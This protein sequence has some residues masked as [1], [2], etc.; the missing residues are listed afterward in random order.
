M[1]RSEPN[2]F[3]PKNTY[4]VMSISAIMVDYISLTKQ[5]K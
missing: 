1:I 2:S 5:Y 3:Q 4:I